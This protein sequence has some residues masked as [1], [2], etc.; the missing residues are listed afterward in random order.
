LQLSDLTVNVNRDLLGQVALGDGRGHLSD[1]AYLTREVAGHRVDIV[2]EVF[3]GPGRP[4]H[5]GLAAQPALGTHLARYARDFRG[6]G[7]QLIHHDIDRVLQLEDLALH[8]DRDLL[9]E[10][11]LLHRGRDVG[12]GAELGGGDVRSLVD[13]L[14]HLFPGPGRTGP[15]GV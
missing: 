6:E 9:G 4:L 14:R 5:V 7:V 13:L 15:T 11:A 3:P 8:L 2:G 10:V 1:I 12:D